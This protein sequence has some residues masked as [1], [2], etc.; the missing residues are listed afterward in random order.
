MAQ[1]TIH[2]AFAEELIRRC[3]LTQP[4]RFLLGSLL[5][6][7]YTDVCY[8][9][10]THFKNHSIPGKVFFDFEQF[11]RQFGEAMACDELYLGWY[12]HILEDDFYRELMHNKYHIGR[13][14]KNT[15]NIK[16]P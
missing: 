5:P 7:A 10:A 6:D 11:R 14:T 1:R 4:E 8:R 16:S 2:Y 15:D 13:L 3:G 12:T 9:D